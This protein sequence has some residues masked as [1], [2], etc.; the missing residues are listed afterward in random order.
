MQI[1]RLHQVAAFAQDLDEAVGFY[2]DT[3]GA[4]YIVR[5]GRPGLAFF[6]LLGVRLLLEKGASKATLL[7]GGRHRRRLR[8]AGIQKRLLRTGASPDLSRCGRHVGPARFRRVDDVLS[9]SIW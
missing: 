7:L 9:R 5:Y 2:R 3:L 4:E 1:T 8:R 6:N